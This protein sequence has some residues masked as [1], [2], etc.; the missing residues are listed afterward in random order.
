MSAG[1]TTRAAHESS[2]EQLMKQV[3][4]ASHDVH[5]G[6][7]VTG[8]A[9]GVPGLASMVGTVV[10]TTHQPSTHSRSLGQDWPALQSKDS[11]RLSK[12]QAEAQNTSKP[13]SI[14]RIRTS[15]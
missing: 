9:S 2:A 5:S 3:P 4:S 8:G 12:L 11:E 15:T 14:V 6:G 10:D 7:H 13:T 1:H